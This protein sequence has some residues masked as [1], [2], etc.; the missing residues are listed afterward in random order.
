MLEL[1]RTKTFKKEAI[2]YLACPL[3]GSDL[4]LEGTELTD[5]QTGTLTCISGCQSYPTQGGVPR[6]LPELN[7]QKHSSEEY[8]KSTERSFSAQWDLYEYGNTTWGTTVSDRVQVVLHELDWSES[9][10]S[11]KVILDAGCGNGTLSR[12]L[13]DRG[14]TVV[15]V[16]LSESVFRAQDNCATLGLHFVQGNLFFPPFRTG[17]FDAIYSCGVFHHT[18][19]T[20]R[21]FDALVPILKDDSQVRYFVWLYSKR[22]WLF[23]ATVEQLMKL[24]RRMPS[25]MLVPACVGMAPAVEIGAR[26]ITL[27]KIVEYAPR[28]LR[29][30]AI[31]LHDLLSP[32]FVH[33]HSF[34]EAKGWAWAKGF[35]SAQKTTYSDS[36]HPDGQTSKIL[37]RYQTVCRPGFGML[38]RTRRVAE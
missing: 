37:Q 10:L 35:Q 12:A 25:W 16:D 2:Q 27:L 32:A 4:R 20:R 3:C 36:G 24:A 6:L 23:N 34:E 13:V 17:V 18:P 1:E 31:Q 21:C 5:I 26:F 28:N 11:G 8:Q 38:C 9:D 29:D 7:E 22:S 15:G 33:Y 30:R 14:A 19:D